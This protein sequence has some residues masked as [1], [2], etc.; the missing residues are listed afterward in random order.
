[1]V[2]GYWPPFLLLRASASRLLNAQLANF[3]ASYGYFEFLNTTAVEPPQLPEA[4]PPAVHCG[5]G[6][7]AHLP[8]VLG[9]ELSR[10]LVV[11]AAPMIDHSWPESS[12]FHCGSP[13]PGIVSTRSSSIS[14]CQ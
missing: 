7:T 10:S 13:R 5:I 14:F 12:A 3:E 8:A 4:L 6:A 2:A 1:M 9:A 11:Q